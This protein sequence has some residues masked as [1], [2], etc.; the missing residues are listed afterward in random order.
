[1]ATDA[2]FTHLIPITP[3][4]ILARC[5]VRVVPDGF[6]RLVAYIG[7]ARDTVI[8]I[9]R[10]PRNTTGGHIADF[11]PVAIGAVLAYRIVRRMD[12]LVLCF[13]A[14]VIGACDTVR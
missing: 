7:R 10:C 6:R 9:K 13:I 8:R 1:M 14:L 5:I 4:S 11:L 2:W 12:D 3:S